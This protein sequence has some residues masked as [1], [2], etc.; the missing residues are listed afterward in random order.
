M[1]VGGKNDERTTYVFEDFDEDE[2]KA[3]EQNSERHSRY[4]IKVISP[5]KIKARK[6]DSKSPVERRRL[7][8]S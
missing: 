7:S 4:N 3:A 5:E 6:K 1:N 2:N 8:F